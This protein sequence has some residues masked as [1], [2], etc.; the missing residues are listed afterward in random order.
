M[1]SKKYIIVLKSGYTLDIDMPIETA[2]S[3][4]ET[5]DSADPVLWWADGTMVR[6]SEIAAIINKSPEKRGKGTMIGKK[7][8]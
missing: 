5:L 2:I 3:I 8:N 1:S 4:K 7:R 6:K